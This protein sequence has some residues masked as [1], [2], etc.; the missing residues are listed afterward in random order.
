ML[1][2]SLQ[3]GSSFWAWVMTT[4]MKAVEQYFPVAVARFASYEEGARSVRVN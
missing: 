2:E 1:R 3:G 4:Q